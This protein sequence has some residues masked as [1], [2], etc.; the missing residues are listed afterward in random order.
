MQKNLKWLGLK[1][2]AFLLDSQL[3]ILK[4]FIAVSV[5]YLI[6]MAFPITRM[7]MISVLLGVMYTLEP[8]N[9][10]GL[11]SGINQMLA[12]ALGALV[13]GF[14]IYLVG[15]Q[16]SF[17][18]VGLGIAL[19]MYISLKIDYRMVS[20]VAIFTS[21]YMNLLLQKD[22]LGNPSIWLTLRLRFLALGLGILIALIF[23]YLFSFLYYRKIGYK[24]LEFVRLHTVR[25]LIKTRELLAGEKT[26]D[27]GLSVL[28]GLFSDVEMVKAN[29]ETMMAEKHHPLSN[30]ERSKLDQLYRMVNA[31]KNVVHLAYD[32]L[33]LREISDFKVTSE[34]LKRLDRMI[35]LLEPID[36]MN[37]KTLPLSVP[38]TEATPDKPSRFDDN[39][40]LMSD[41]LNQLLGLAKDL[42]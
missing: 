1:R 9:V 18:T 42:A 10:L 24:R 2:E 28:A 3:Y 29:L 39:L 35:A 11:K 22:A 15:Y 12:A 7:D 34:D 27:A 36:F 20:P 37:L 31:L 6:G 38:Q 14:L 21:I 40:G 26:G 19:T 23:N 41:Q 25:G 30:L 8:V 17:M 5:G 4:G 13:T 16:V 32:C 33:Y